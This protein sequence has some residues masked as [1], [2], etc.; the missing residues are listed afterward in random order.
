MK[1]PKRL[2]PKPLA[3]F[4]RNKIGRRLGRALGLYSP[5]TTRTDDRNL[6]P[7]LSLALKF[8]S[9]ETRKTP[10]KE[11]FPASRLVII[12]DLN[13]PQCKKYRVL[14][15][16]ELLSGHG[17][18][19]LFSHWEDH[20]RAFRLMQTATSVV[21]YR[22]PGSS[23]YNEYLHEAKRLRL[24]IGYDIDDPIYDQS[25]YMN[26]SNL[27]YLSAKEKK[28]LL[29]SSVRY[30]AAMMAA[31]FLLTSTTYMQQR[32]ASSFEGKPVYRLQ[33][34]LDSE[35]LSCANRIRMTSNS[36][37]STDTIVVSYASGSRAHEADFRIAEKAMARLL[38][39]HK[40]VHFQVLG[41]LDLP[42][43]FT[44]YSDRITR[45]PFTT[46]CGYL[47]K[48]NKSDIVIVPLVQNNFN[49]CKSAIR[50]LEAGLLKKA[51]ITSNVGEFREAIQ[52]GV[53]G[54]L[55][56]EPDWYNSL[57]KIVSD[58]LFRMSLGKEA[59]DNVLKNYTKSAVLGRM[60][61]G[62]RKILVNGSA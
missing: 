57:D 10:V 2:K 55:C 37:P 16:I 53:N 39:A 41:H 21:L 7:H 31:D 17:I 51:T 58:D 22:V 42:A 61:D 6:T 49:E 38:K 33:N 44:E 8:S 20:Y 1:L 28:S 3:K 46:H 9:D 26:N 34:Y 19:V 30:S 36:S 59:H 11:L 35:S 27:D 29:S 54:I 25:I 40:Q 15:K 43:C 4:F 24:K 45:I 60:E 18:E 23:L 12:A 47:E 13:L 32:M 48:L 50:Y 14:Q 62:L 52:T 56:D 5:V